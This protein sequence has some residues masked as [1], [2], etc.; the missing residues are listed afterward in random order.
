MAGV[1]SAFL[2]FLALVLSLAEAFLPFLGRGRV[3]QVCFTSLEVRRQL[4][5]TAY[6]PGKG[7]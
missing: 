7:R 3:K 2:P 1:G 5:A 4:W 6:V